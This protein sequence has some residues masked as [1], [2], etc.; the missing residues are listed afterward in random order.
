MKDEQIKTLNERL[1][2][3][4]ERIAVLT[5]QKG[6][7]Q[8]ANADR[9]E[10]RKFD[11]ERIADRDVIIAKQQ[12]EIDRLRHPGL[13]ASIFD[14]RSVYGFVAGFGGC[15]LTNGGTTNPLQQFS[16]Q[17]TNQWL[18]TEQGQKFLDQFMNPQERQRKA[19]Q[20][21]FQK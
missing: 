7:L 3:K 15:K 17:Q 9:Q 1:V 19:L 21:L 13:F 20:K 6:G 16:N 10:A 12:A 14:K 2:V 4:D 5:E 8:G 18:Q 11:L